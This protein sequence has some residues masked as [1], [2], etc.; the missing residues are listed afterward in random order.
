[1]SDYSGTDNLEIMKEAVNYNRFLRRLILKYARGGDLILDFGAGIGTFASWV[2]RQGY[3]VCCLEVD[4]AQARIIAQQNLQVLTSLSD[5]RDETYDYVYSLNVLEH[6]EDDAQALRD[7]FRVV[8]PGGRVLLY[9]PALQILFS[10][11]DRKVGHFRRYRK[12]SLK[13]LAVESGFT[14][15]KCRYADSLGVF[16]TLVYKWFG[17]ES[18]DLSMAPLV[19]YDRIA[20]PISRL[21]DILLGAICGKNVYAVL[22]KQAAD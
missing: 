8:K 4:G 13:Q 3:D 11:M 9:L 2:G 18:G 12:S 15:A 16:A 22:V 21:L 7:I 5:T 17:D 20:F 1:M 14:V 6:I 19:L 10:S